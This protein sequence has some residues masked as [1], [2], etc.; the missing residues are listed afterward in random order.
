M[1]SGWTKKP[2]V[3]H[4]EVEGEIEGYAEEAAKYTL[5]EVQ[6]VSPVETGVYRKSHYMKR[7]PVGWMIS[8]ND[9]PGKAWALE[10][11]HSTKAPNGVYSVTFAS[12]QAKYG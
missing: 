2:S 10:H 12:L 5:Q 6:Q 8:T 11:G 4:L 7:I 1:A 3:Y 9:I